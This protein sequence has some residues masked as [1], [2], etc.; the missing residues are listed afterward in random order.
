MPNHVHAH[1]HAHAYAHAYAQAHVNDHNHACA[2]SSIPVL[3]T[4]CTARENCIND[5]FFFSDASISAL[6]V[7]Y[8]ARD[9]NAVSG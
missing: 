7:S 6:S 9:A 1:A 5:F 8:V 2:A 4:L 3:S